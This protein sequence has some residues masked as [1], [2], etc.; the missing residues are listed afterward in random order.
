MNRQSRKLGTHTWTD[1]GAV[2]FKD[3]AIEEA[4]DWAIGQECLVEVRDQDNPSQI[5]N[6][7]VQA[8]IKFNVTGLRGGDN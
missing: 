5:F 6:L 4:R 8:D 3:A 7:V 1:R 2:S